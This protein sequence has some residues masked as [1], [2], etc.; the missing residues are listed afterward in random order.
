MSRMSDT[1]SRKPVVAGFATLE[2]LLAM[3]I[4]VLTLA[5]VTLTTY[6]SQSMQMD[7]ETGT[8]ALHSAQD[9]LELMQTL[10]RKDFHLVVPTSSDETIGN[11]T[12]HRVV[13]VTPT[14]APDYATKQITS[15]VTWT[16]EHNRPQHVSL[17]ALVTNFD[18]AAG[19]D[20]C[21]SVPSG[22]WGLPII[23]NSVTDIPTL[24][25]TSSGVNVVTGVDAYKGKL[26]VT[27]N[28]S[29]YRTDPRLF[30]LDIAKLKTDPTHALLGKLTTATNTTTYG[31]NSV[32]V[33]EGPSGRLYAYIADDYGANW[34]AC[35]PYYNCAQLTI[36]EVTEPSK[37]ALG[38]STYYKLPNIFG[39]LGSGGAGYSVY[40]KDG[41]LYLGLTKTLS[42]PEF[43]IIDVHDPKNPLWLGGLNI[44]FTVN[45]IRVVGNVAYLATSDGS[46]DVLSVD[47]SNPSNPTALASFDAA[48]GGGTIG[49]GQSLAAVGDTL[50]LGRTNVDG[51]PEF[52][53]VDAS[54]SGVMLLPQGSRDVG[55]AANHFSIFGIVVRGVFAFLVGGD[56]SSGKLYIE[57]IQNKSNIF[58]ASLP[59]T[60]PNNSMGYALDCEGNDIFVGSRD[61]S[62]VGHIS[63]ITASP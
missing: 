32:Q 31:M 18:H 62:N 16:G 51:S 53:I 58:D 1:S 24:T 22:N 42:G 47:V 15:T 29:Q 54:S 23:A 43:N 59:L 44:D 61:G 26:Y 38:S 19:G 21:D 36:A 55:T 30:V 40:Y 49:L 5:S 27:V 35:S 28:S 57:Q 33:A 45:A 48:G 20:T 13:S 50:F 4:L 39:S 34:G 2:V 52:S 8:E 46:R 17:S 37:M 3:T 25:A 12:Y 56:G 11:L 41:L 10:S 60:L 63:V 9:G 14:A 7:A 6:G